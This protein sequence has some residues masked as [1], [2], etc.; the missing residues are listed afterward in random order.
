MDIF[1]EIN[2]EGTALMLVTHDAKVAARTDRIMFMDDGKIVSELKLPK[3]EGKDIE[4]RIDEV[5]VKMR[6]VGI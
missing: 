4:D 2:A 6:E 3:F 1:S 5:T